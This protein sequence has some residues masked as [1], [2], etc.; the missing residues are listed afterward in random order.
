MDVSLQGIRT[1]KYGDHW[2]VSF[3][4]PITGKRRRLTKKETGLLPTKDEAQAW[5]TEHMEATIKKELDLLKR[6]EWRQAVTMVQLFNEYSAYKKK[7]AP[8][9][10][11][12]DL[13]TLEN[14]G[15]P[16]FLTVAKI[17]NPNEWIKE[18]L[19]FKSWLLE[20]A[21]TEKGSTLA[22]SS[23]NKAINSFNKFN[24]WL[25]D[26]ARVLEWDNFRSLQCYP[27]SMQNQKGADDLVDDDEFSLVCERLLKDDE[28]L[29]LDMFKVQRHTGMRVSELLGLCLNSLTNKIPDVVSQAFKDAGYLENF[30]AI[31]LESQP[32]DPYIKR[33]D[34]E[35]PRKA[36]K[37][38]KEISPKNSRTI[39]ITD[40]AI[41]NILARRFKGEKENFAKQAFGHRKDSYLLFDGAQ[42]NVYLTT[43]REAYEKTGLRFKGSHCLRHTRSTELSMRLMPVKIQEL[44]LGHKG[45]AQERYQHIVEVL[46]QRTR[47]AMEFDEIDEIA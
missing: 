24:E 30:G 21:R 33:V 27:M 2:W 47:E 36:L 40:K 20:G 12:Q 15:L 43:L 41:W 18:Q 14:F 17:N 1:K 32:R 37:W 9:S 35:I 39:P 31:Y 8:K 45:Q 29:A 26:H 5:V 22:V 23:A 42:R 10:Y 6:K 44:V 11:M 46:N 28:I 4:S 19:R 38:R 34:G 16:Y 7:A 25:R 13:S 3:V